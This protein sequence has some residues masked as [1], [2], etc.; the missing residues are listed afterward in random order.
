M[1]VNTDMTLFNRYFDKDSEDYRYSV[2]HL[3]GVNW[4]DSQGISISKEGVTSVD[5]TRIFIPLNVD[6]SGKEYLK[7]KAF[8]RM[9]NKAQNYTLDNEDVVVKG[10]INFD[11]NNADTGGLSA[12]QRDYD[13]VMLITRV[14]DNRHGSEGVQHF[15]LEVR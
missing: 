1:L 5:N 15:E 11:I 2:T 7:P 3:R 10:I 8:R 13:D 9:K 4:Q 6:S 12:L 14:A